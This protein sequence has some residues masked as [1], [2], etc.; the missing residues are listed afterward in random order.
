ML[1]RRLTRLPSDDMAQPAKAPAAPAA[2]LTS[3]AWLPRAAEDVAGWPLG[4][5]AVSG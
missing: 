3:A 4:F 5:N 2:E 1:A